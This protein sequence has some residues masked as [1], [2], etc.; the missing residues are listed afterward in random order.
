MAGMDDTGLEDAAILL[1]SLG[2]EQAA[3]AFKHLSPKEVQRLG[4]TIAR[5]KTVQRER[6]EGVIERFAKLAT[7]EQ[8]LVPDSDQY[9]RAVLRKAAQFGGAGFLLCFFIVFNCFFSG[10][11]LLLF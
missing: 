10:G 7:S 8:M 9:V 6:F 11:L 1:M 4:E 3:E 2:E 5:M